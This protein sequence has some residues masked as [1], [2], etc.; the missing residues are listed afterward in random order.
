MNIKQRKLNQEF[1]E[2]RLGNNI[3]MMLHK[4]GYGTVTYYFHTFNNQRYICIKAD[5]H[6]YEYTV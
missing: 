3:T 2:T 5:Y 1:M 6:T 4:I